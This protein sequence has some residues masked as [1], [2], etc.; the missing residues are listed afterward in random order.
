MSTTKHLSQS[1]H[2][3]SN[4]KKIPPVW[5]K[6]GYRL[7]S[8]VYKEILETKAFI[9]TKKITKKSDYVRLPTGRSAGVH[10]KTVRDWLDAPT[11]AFGPKTL[12]SHSHQIQTPSTSACRSTLRKR[13]AR[14]ATTTQMSSMLLWKS[15]AVDEGRLHQELPVS[16]R[17]CYCGQSTHRHQKYFDVFGCKYIF[18]IIYNSFNFTPNYVT[19]GYCTKRNRTFAR[20]GM[21]VS[22]PNLSYTA[23][24]SALFCT[25]VYK[26]RFRHG[27]LHVAISQSFPSVAFS[28]YTRFLH[29]NI[30]M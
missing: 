27:S 16:I 23:C 29:L 19:I 11:W 14:H 5:L 13:L 1:W 20:S 22:V 28:K 12:C 8:A 30:S 3:T 10:A 9:W 17:A 7:T 15:I 21:N 2:P 24:S 26:F 6:L 18:C 25:F 4:G